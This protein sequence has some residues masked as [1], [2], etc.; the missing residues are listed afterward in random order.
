VHEYS[1]GIPRVANVLCDNSM[2][3]AFALASQMV[4]AQMVHES[5]RDLGLSAE[6]S[7]A[8][9]RT[10]RRERSGTPRGWLRRLWSGRST[11]TLEI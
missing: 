8:G 4:S 2:L 1:A 10:T 9:A 5:A 6:R 7:R 3:L 11:R